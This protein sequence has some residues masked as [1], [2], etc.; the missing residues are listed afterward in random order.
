[1]SVLPAALE[2]ITDPTI[3][4]DA[5]SRLGANEKRVGVPFV[6][7]HIQQPVGRGHHF[8]MVAEREGREK[9][10]KLGSGEYI[11]D[12]Y[13][14]TRLKGRIK[15]IEQETERI[16]AEEWRRVSSEEGIETKLGECW[17]LYPC[18]IGR[19]WKECL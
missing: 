17:S 1:M 6:I 8:Q 10:K 9:G 4:R 19:W 18:D 11:L 15:E 13:N 14:K 7:E 3:V 5:L 16:L 2:E 12:I